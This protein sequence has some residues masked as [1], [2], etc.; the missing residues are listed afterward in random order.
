[1]YS[2]ILV[3]DKKKFFLTLVFSFLTLLKQYCC[4]L[5]SHIVKYHQNIHVIPFIE[6]KVWKNEL[7]NQPVSHS[8]I[9]LHHSKFEIDQWK[10]SNVKTGFQIHFF[11]FIILEPDSCIAS[12]ILCLNQCTKMMNKLCS[13]CSIIVGFL[14]YNS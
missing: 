12:F 10:D 2:S 7:K 14:L 5:P 4:L 1:M 13:T 3:Y 9:W 11:F 8:S 6:S